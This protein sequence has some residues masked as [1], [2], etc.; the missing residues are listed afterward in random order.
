MWHADNSTLRFE[1][2]R[3]SAAVHPRNPA[4]GVRDVCVDGI[5]LAQF[6]PLCVVIPPAESRDAPEPVSPL[7]A[8]DVDFYI[9]GGDLIA[10][11]FNRPAR[12]MRT[13]IYWRTATHRSAG[14]IAALELVVSVQTNLL[15]SCPRI[16]A[17]SA[18][19]ASE[20]LQLADP[21]RGTFGSANSRQLSA[22]CYLF[23]LAN[24]KYS[25]VQIVHPGDAQQSDLQSQ[26]EG[27]AGCVELRH[28]LFSPKLEKGVI[29]R[30]RVLGLL[31]DRA[32][33]EAAA[34]GHYAAFLS[35]DLPLTT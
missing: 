5:G 21:D 27:G 18:I 30:A 20:V 7:P 10:T 32:G 15:D 1:L 24:G 25:Y 16:T 6:R 26:A 23:R 33:D 14:A 19:P 34:A 3:F 28:E 9:R 8:A 13:Q 31:V 17:R 4:D 35:Q 12:A 2:A 11:Y 22:P 29:L